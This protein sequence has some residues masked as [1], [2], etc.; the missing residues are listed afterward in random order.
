MVSNDPSTSCETHRVLI[1][2]D[3][4]DTVDVMSMIFTLLGHQP[5][6]VLSGREAI[7]AA[8]TFDPTLIVLDIG[9]R[10]INGYEVVRALRADPKLSG[11]YI[12]ALTGWN[13]AQD[14]SNSAKAGF[15]CHVIKPIDLA[16]IRQILRDA[17]VHRAH[18]IANPTAIGS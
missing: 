3:D 8:R 13:S 9:L 4:P 16:N 12:V 11:G 15:D 2:D 10:D 18:T 6:G 14:I 17:D 5:Q 7:H 1:V